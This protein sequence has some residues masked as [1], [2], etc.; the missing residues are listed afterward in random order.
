[1]M[2]IF[3]LHGMKQVV[4]MV[5]FRSRSWSMVRAAITPGTLHPVPT[6]NGIKDLPDSPNRRN[7]R[8]MMKA[9]RDI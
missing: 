8:S 9:T 7:S 3:A 5:I 1:M 2:G 6:S 4:M